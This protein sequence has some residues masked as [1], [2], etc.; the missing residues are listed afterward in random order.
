MDDLLFRPNL[1]TLM[2]N[3]VTRNIPYVLEIFALL[4]CVSLVLT[5]R[6]YKLRS[7]GSLLYNS[8]LLFAFVPRLL[9][10]LLLAFQKPWF[11][12]VPTLVLGFVTFL[13]NQLSNPLFN[14]LD[15][16]GKVAY[17]SAGS[18]VPITMTGPT[19]EKNASGDS[20]K[21]QK[22]NK[23]NQAVSSFLINLTGLLGI[24]SGILLQYSN[25]MYSKS[26]SSL[27]L[28]PTGTDLKILCLS[29][30]AAYLFGSILLCVYYYRHSDGDKKLTLKDVSI[31]PKTEVDEETLY[32]EDNEQAA[33]DKQNTANQN[34]K[35]QNFGILVDFGRWVTIPRATESSESKVAEK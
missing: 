33:E 27:I 14:S 16:C 5:L 3:I 22:K 7:F 19:L 13:V 9:M 24:L 2:E 32:P 21:Y 25:A 4:S 20:L 35:A 28:I 30:L 15:L 18:M 8:G 10:T 29:S 34:T 23:F 17:V 31:L 12:I 6:S 1:H 26:L 11:I